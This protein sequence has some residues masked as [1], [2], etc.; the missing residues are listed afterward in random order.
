[1][2]YLARHSQAKPLEGHIDAPTGAG[3][4]RS[5][6]AGAG[7]AVLV[8]GLAFAAFLVPP[9]VP[10]VSADEVQ[11]VA[12]TV[13]SSLTPVPVVEQVSI[14]TTLDDGTPAPGEGAKLAAGACAHGL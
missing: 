10:P 2:C 3:Q 7:A 1:M 11:A 6:W 8:A 13:V 9:A 14:S 4:D 12:E 5:R